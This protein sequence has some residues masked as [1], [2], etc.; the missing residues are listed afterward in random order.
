[1]TGTINLDLSNGDVGDTG[2]AV[3]VGAGEGEDFGFELAQEFLDDGGD[4]AAV[5]ETGE[6]FIGGAHHLA[7][8]LDGGGTHLS[9]DILYLGFHFGLG[10][11]LGEVFLQVSGSS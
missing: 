4:G 5:G 8:I 6:G 1:M 7:H 9:N 11:L 2:G 3:G 10:K